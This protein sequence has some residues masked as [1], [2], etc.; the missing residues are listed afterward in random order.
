M[1]DAYLTQLLTEMFDEVEHTDH[2]YQVPLPGTPTVVVLDGPNAL[3]RVL[4]SA[5]LLTDVEPTPQVLAT[6]NDLNTRLPFGR[7]VLDD[8]Q[9][10]I[11]HLLLGRTLDHAGLDN[12]VRFVSWA[13]RTST[14]ELAAAAGFVPVRSS[15]PGPVDGSQGAGDPTPAQADSPTSAA[16]TA[17]A[18]SATSTLALTGA[19]RRSVSNAA[20]YL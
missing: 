2:G 10:I 20:G 11:E 1:V 12:A 5:V 19:T 9:V 15:A 17:T 4:T 3:L 13:A 8:G 18:V 14:E 7:A 6:I 16:A